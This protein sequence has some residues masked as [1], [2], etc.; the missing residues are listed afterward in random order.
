[1]LE[2]GKYNLLQ[3]IRETDSGLYLE[4]TEG[5]EVLLPGK[6]IPQSASI[7]DYL[8]VF[9]Y[10]DNL[11]RITATTQEAQI[12]LYEFAYLS[13]RNVT[14]KGAYVDIG[15]DKDLFV[16]FREQKLKME[17][18]RSYMIYMY[19]DGQTGRLTGSAKI[20]QFLDF[21]SVDLSEGEE[22]LIR[23]WDKTDLG[24]KVIINNLYAGLLYSNEIF[25]NL[26]I[27]EQRSAY[28]FKIREDGKV[29]VRLELDGYAKVEPNT[30]K[31]LT[32]LKENKH[33]MPLHD[34]SSPED[35]RALL[36]MS[37]KTFKKAIGNLYKQKK[38]ALE[39]NGIR[40][41]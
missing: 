8:E 7:D 41:L 19:L 10:L 17:T 9:L 21:D 13:V 23:I 34:K 5:N 1:M 16:P 3:I 39:S 24:F 28:V 11:G 18:G 33:F 36:S 15:I 40:L 31:I 14:E 25:E 38:I 26:S 32:Y 2:L 6:F 22:V 12:C 30:F 29:D 27:G 37:K 20:D 35:I 4:D